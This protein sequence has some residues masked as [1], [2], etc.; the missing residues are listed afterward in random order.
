MP[1]EMWLIK[2][3]SPVLSRTGRLGRY[4]SGH[5]IIGKIN[6]EAK[7]DLAGRPD[8]SQWCRSFRNLD[9]MND[10]PLKTFR[11]ADV[12]DQKIHNL[13]KKT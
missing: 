3:T 10:T 5:A 1:H 6:K 11:D 8:E 4:Q 2:K 7:R 9:N 13:Q 12:T